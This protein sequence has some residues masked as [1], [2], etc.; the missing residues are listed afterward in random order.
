MKHFQVVHSLLQY[1]F[2]HLRVDM[3]FFFL[4]CLSYFQKY[5]IGFVSLLDRLLMEVFF[6]KKYH[7]NVI[8][9]CFNKLLNC[10]MDFFPQ[11]DLL[12]IIGPVLKNAFYL[13]FLWKL[14]F[15]RLYS[16]D[17]VLLCE[18]MVWKFSYI[19]IW[20][21]SVLHCLRNCF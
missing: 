13:I 18:R 19:F 2:L 6:L 10:V 3:L 7:I 20:V 15:V 17:I 21:I 11:L 5:S 1:S 14:L 9:N 8:I 16:I 12:F 4:L